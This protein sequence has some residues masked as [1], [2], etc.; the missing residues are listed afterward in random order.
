M[1][2][3][4]TTIRFALLAASA[5][6]CSSCDSLDLAPLDYYGSGNYWT[7][8]EHII[9]YMDGIHK[10]LRDKAY[11]HQFIF[12]EVRAGTNVEALAV[13]GTSVSDQVLKTQKLTAIS[14]GV[15][16]WGEL[17]GLIANI[18]I[19]LENTK[20][21]TYMSE[22]DKAFYL[23]QAYGLRAFHY[24]D[25]Y[26]IYGTAP[27]RL[28]PNPVVGGNFNPEDLYEGRASGST[29]MK[30]IKADLDESL[31]YFGNENSFDPKNRGNKKGYWSKAAT[32][33]LMGEVYL[34]N[35][36]VSIDDNK[37]DEN[38]LAVAKTHLQNVINNYGLSLQPKFSDVFSPTNKGNSEIIFAIRYVEGEA[39]NFYTYFMYNYQ[40]GY[41]KTVGYNDENGNA[42]GD[43][44]QVGTTAMQRHE[45]KKELFL[46]YDKA[47]SRRDGTFL[48]AYYKEDNKLA[49]TVLRK[50]M[51]H[52]NTSTNQ[53]VWD[54]DAVIYRL[55]MVYMMLAEI[56]NMQGGDVAHYINLVRERAYGD[57]WDINKYG[58]KNADFTTN[59][60]AI[61]NEKD[62]EFVS[63]GQRWWDVCRMTLTKGGKHL[64]FCKE[65]S[66]G[67]DQPILNEATEAYKVLW[68]IETEMINKD[69]KV[70]QTPG[71]EI[72][73]EK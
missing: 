59:E 54:A 44:L 42:M 16:K 22:E 18:N 58:Y 67:N 15:N 48:S 21:A 39:S 64:V 10:N 63:E 46:K 4:K 65:A 11:Q 12:G 7:K 13:D 25:L 60:L 56:E 28:D 19:F 17:Y 62:K 27:L 45:Y 20:A 3:L 1:N 57:N 14:P 68:P 26:R 70:K 31:K 73:N 52:F 6:L 41:F 8:P 24:F 61:L 32:E 47:D 51:G 40:T 9:G 53:Y 5:Y 34:W 38:D 69:P 43:T 29:L 66:L 71:Y 55:P 50:T 37:A 72:D 49:G 33:F 2:I 23:G 30:Q 36:K 35:A